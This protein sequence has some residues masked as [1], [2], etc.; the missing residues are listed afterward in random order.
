MKGK[1]QG[2]N[3]EDRWKIILEENEVISKLETKDRSLPHSLSFT[4]PS[5]G[6]ES[7]SFNALVAFSW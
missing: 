5:P 4:L 7:H 6:L 1:N 2:E 3:G